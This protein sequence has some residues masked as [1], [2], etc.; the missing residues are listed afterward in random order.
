MTIALTGCQE[1][2]GG[3]TEGGGREG[4]MEGGGRERREKE[5]GIKAEERRRIKGI[6]GGCRD[7]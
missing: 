4:K 7:R 1:G 6:E 3:K 2:R 5:E